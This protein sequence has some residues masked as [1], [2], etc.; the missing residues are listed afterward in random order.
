[1]LITLVVHVTKVLLF[2]NTI[3]ISGMMD[4]TVSKNITT[5]HFFLRNYSIIK[6]NIQR[7]KQLMGFL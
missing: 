5:A 4:E 3:F 1:M 7:K 6:R 2:D